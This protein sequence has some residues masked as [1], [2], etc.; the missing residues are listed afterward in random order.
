MGKLYTD[1]LVHDEAALRYLLQTMGT[2]KVLLGSDYPFPLGEA[3]PGKLVDSLQDCDQDTKV[4]HPL[5][6]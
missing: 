3:H 4:A 5:Y 1:S 2:E 6:N